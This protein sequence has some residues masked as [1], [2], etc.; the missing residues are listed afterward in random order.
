MVLRAWFLNLD[1]DDELSR[2][3]GY[4]PSQAML[5]RSAELAC[6]VSRLLGPGDIVIG[7]GPSDRRAQGCEGR[8]WCPTPRALR[9]IEA[10]GARVPPAP[11]V[12][13]LRRVNHRRFC[14]GLGQMLPGAAY[15]DAMADL[16]EAIAGPSPLGQWLI[17]RPFGFAGRGRR[18][19]I[20]GPLSRPDEAWVAASLRAGE[21]LQVEP[22]VS[23][24][25]DFA[26]HGH[27]SRD[28]QLD[29]GEPT[30]QSCDENGA[31]KSTTAA[32]PQDLS[33]IELR[34]LL[35]A[36]RDAANA[37]IDSGYFGPFGIDAYRW[38]DAGGTPR[39]NPR[40]EINARY[41]MGWAIGMGS[42]R[43][44]LDL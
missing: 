42:R 10:S 5:A 27:I 26:L 9:A 31:W 17:K 41:S 28:G 2:P 30:L 38:R 20:A 39:F 13:V 34:A 36:A 29:L 25:G 43:P 1:A 7:E 14:A 12:H 4:G 44:D 8:A 6:H 33:G 18:K 37:L 22:L 23:R 16:V 11:A 21:G 3:L 15:V 32:A 35:D 40:S 24:T 19:V